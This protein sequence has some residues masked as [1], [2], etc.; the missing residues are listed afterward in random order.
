ML[1]SEI[2]EST[3]DDFLQP[4]SNPDLNPAELRK[5]FA[6]ELGIELS[7]LQDSHEVLTLINTKLLEIH[8]S[9]K[10]IVLLID[11]AQA[12][13]IESLEALRLL[14]NLE[15]ATT[16][17]LQVV[18]FGQPELDEHLN[19]P[20][21]RQLKQRIGFSYYLPTL[22]REDVDTYLFYRLAMAGNNYGA[23]F[24]EKARDRL[25]RASQ[26]IPRIINILCHKAL[27]FAY[28][29]GESVVTHQTM[30]LAIQDT[31]T[32][33]LQRVSVIFLVSTGLIFLIAIVFAFYFYEGII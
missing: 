29:R 12:L 2:V 13:P 15:T 6:R 4:I 20:S 3:G 31:E 8:Q 9:G 7:Y 25:F 17:L 10:R 23:L 27:L 14:T 18:L 28:G 1:C 30:R 11:E 16:K 22:S 5:A 32:A 21:L 19:R 33:S 24:T 26:G